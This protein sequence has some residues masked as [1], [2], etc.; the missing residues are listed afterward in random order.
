MG[1]D[2]SQTCPPSCHR[3]MSIASTAVAG[4]HRPWKTA[5]LSAQLLH[6]ALKQRRLWPVA[7]KWDGGHCNVRCCRQP[8]NLPHPG[9]ATHTLPKGSTAG[10]SGSLGG[11]QVSRIGWS[12]N[13]VGGTALCEPPC[14]DCVAGATLL[15]TFSHCLSSV[16]GGPPMREVARCLQ[17]PCLQCPPPHCP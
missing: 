5:F 8:T 10:S 11:V 9:E 13:F 6:T 12:A 16:G 15:H 14:A 4:L 1:T 7:G 17:L 2:C 3:A